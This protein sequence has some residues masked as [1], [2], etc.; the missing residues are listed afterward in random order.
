MYNLGLDI[1]PIMENNKIITMARSP[2]DKEKI[3]EFRTVFEQVLS[4]QG[5]NKA[6]VCRALGRSDAWLSKILS[7]TRGMDVLDLMKIADILKINPGRLL[8]KSVFDKE[9]AEMET[10]RKVRDVLTAEQFNKLRKMEPK[11]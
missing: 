4:D 11:K 10:L 9:D 3:K 8:P 5:W 6:K 2:E 1:L 7:G